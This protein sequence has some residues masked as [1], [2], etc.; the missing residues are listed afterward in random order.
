MNSRAKNLQE[1]KW[2]QRKAFAARLDAMEKLYGDSDEDGE[3][4]ESLQKYHNFC[5]KANRFQTD[6][7]LPC[8]KLIPAPV[9]FT[10]EFISSVKL[11]PGT[12]YG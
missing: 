6:K 2:L 10:I 8:Y 9:P 1:W 5:I 12:T 7:K 11:P 4:K 3:L